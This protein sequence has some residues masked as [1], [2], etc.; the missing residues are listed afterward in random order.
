TM[1]SMV[2]IAEHRAVRYALLNFLSIGVFPVL[3]FFFG[4]QVELWKLVAISAGLTTLICVAL[5]LG[6]VFRN[7]ELEHAEKDRRLMLRFGASRTRGTFLDG[8][9]DAWVLATATAAGIDVLGTGAIALAL[10]LQRGLNPL[11]NA[12]NQVLVPAAARLAAKN[13]AGALAR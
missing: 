6:I 8:S 7:G 5:A 4:L 11:T 2:A 13:E 9:L 10:M 1:I 3:P 12:L